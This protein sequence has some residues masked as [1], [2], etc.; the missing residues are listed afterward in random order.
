MPV[1]AV[2]PRILHFIITDFFVKIVSAASLRLDKIV[3]EG[4]KVSRTDAAAAISGGGKVFVNQKEVQ[5]PDFQL[6][7]GDK[8]TFRGKGK[9]ELSALNG[10]SKKGKLR[11]ELKIY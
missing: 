3:A 10:I 5:K 7:E 4:F 9:I 1:L 6:S 8:I 11:V 2:Y